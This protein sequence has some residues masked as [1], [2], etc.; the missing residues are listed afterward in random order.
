MP[1][2]KSNLNKDPAMTKAKR[3]SNDE[4]DAQQSQTP[5]RNAAG[6]TVDKNARNAAPVQTPAAQG[7]TRRDSGVRQPEGGGGSRSTAGPD[8]LLE[9]S[10]TTRTEGLAG[11]QTTVDEAEVADAAKRTQASLVAGGE[12]LDR[13]DEMHSGDAQGEKGLD[14]QRDR[15]LGDIAGE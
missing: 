15:V 8:A 10:E 9:T 11:S 6:N 5:T 13:T 3:R 12:D 4:L 14:A 2:P 7:S 1:D